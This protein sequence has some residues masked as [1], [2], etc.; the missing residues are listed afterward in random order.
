MK[1]LAGEISVNRPYHEVHD[2]DESA[3]HPESASSRSRDRRRSAGSPP[4]SRT[5]VRPRRLRRP[6]GANNRTPG[7]HPALPEVRRRRHGGARCQRP[8]RRHFLTEVGPDLDRFNSP[9]NFSS[10]LGLCPK[11]S[12]RQP[13]AQRQNPAAFQ[14]LATSTP[15][16]SLPI[17]S[18]SAP[19]R[20]RTGWRRRCAPQRNRRTASSQAGRLVPSHARETRSGRCIHR[21]CATNWRV[22]S[23]R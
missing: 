18:A 14:P 7:A 4:C 13:P 15:S 1:D 5:A 11:K 2:S 21:R 8:R 17:R 20:S 10:W 19:R 9:E 6:S 16:F 22:S 3:R 23:P 12:Q